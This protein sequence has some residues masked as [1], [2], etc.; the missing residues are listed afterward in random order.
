MEER[1]GGGEE[2]TNGR[3]GKTAHRG[4]KWETSVQ[5]RQWER[6]NEVTRER[7]VG[8]KERK[9]KP[10]WDVEIARWEKRETERGG[11]KQIERERNRGK[12]REYRNQ[13]R[14]D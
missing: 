14:R 12:E 9:E 10:N 4:D 7:G 5:E 6:K 13:R 1:R 2:T 8:E 3:K 11:V